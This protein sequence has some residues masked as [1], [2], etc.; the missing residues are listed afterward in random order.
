MNIKGFLKTAVLP[1]ALLAMTVTSAAA[2]EKIF[3][4]INHTDSVIRVWGKSNDYKFGRINTKTIADCTCNALYNKDCFDKKG[5]KAKIKLA[6]ESKNGKDLYSGDTCTKLYVDPGTFIDVTYDTDGRHIRCAIIDKY[7]I[8]QPIPSFEEADV[9]KDGK[10]D[11]Q[12][13]E[14][15]Q[16]KANFKDFDDDLN[17]ELNPKE[18]DR[19]IDKI[20]IFRGVPF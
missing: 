12:E 8:R 2:D 18:F 19:A 13:A 1:A 4:V 3:T 15:I 5:G 10:I 14:A 6:L 17:R 16:L 20:N 9:N 11:E 7:E